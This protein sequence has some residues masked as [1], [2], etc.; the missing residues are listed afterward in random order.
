VA[1]SVPHFKF[2]KPQSPGPKEFHRPLVTILCVW[3]NPSIDLE[4][5]AWVRVIEIRD[6]NIQIVAILAHNHW[7]LPQEF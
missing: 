6:K 7:A 3:L 1:L 5:Q 4:G 2:S